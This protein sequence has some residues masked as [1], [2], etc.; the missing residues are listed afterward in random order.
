MDQDSILLLIIFTVLVG[1]NLYCSVKGKYP[2][3]KEE[4][5]KVRTLNG[6]DMTKMPE[7]LRDT[8]SVKWIKDQYHG[9]SPR[10]ISGALAWRILHQWQELKSQGKTADPTPETPQETTA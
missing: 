2:S 9:K 7:G 8:E 4:G 10:G 6:I 5:G 3:L 1:Y